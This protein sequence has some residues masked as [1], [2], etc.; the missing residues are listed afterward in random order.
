ML[1]LHSN[2][3]SHASSL[4]TYLPTPPPEL[5]P[6]DVKAPTLEPPHVAEE[7]DKSIKS[8]RVVEPPEDGNVNGDQWSGWDTPKPDA[9][10]VAPKTGNPRWPRIR[11]PP[12][13]KNVWPKQRDMK[14]RPSESESD[15]GISCKSNS[16][17]D[18][19]YDVKKLVDWNGDWL[20]PPEEW[21]ARKGHS[22]RH[23]GQGIERWI[24]GHAKDCLTVMEVT[25]LPSFIDERACRE[26]VPKYWI[27][28][29]VEQGS[30]AKFWKLMPT[31]QPTALSDVSTHRPFWERYGEEPIGCFIEGLAI[32]DAKVDMN[33][34]ENNFGG[35]DLLASATDRIECIMERRHKSHRKALAKQK[36]PAHDS[37]P[38]E[39][40]PQVQRFKPLSN[41]YFRPVI[42]A[43]IE[44]ITVSQT[45]AQSTSSNH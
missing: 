28:S 21:S 27:A 43:D 44:G 4:T 18:P 41:V 36:R 14:P 2:R 42:P 35:A 40:R 17:G 5:K 11:G 22:S 13:R 15:G 9:P 16:N 34:P 23:F 3:L 39:P 7:V 32:P 8:G 26:V 37:V 45:C 33:D 10:A 31:R 25:T 30:L 29:R 6:R 19:T 20:P 24:D 12:P 38:V 1:I